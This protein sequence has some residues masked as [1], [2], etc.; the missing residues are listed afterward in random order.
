MQSFRNQGRSAFQP[1]SMRLRR[2]GGRSTKMMPGVNAPITV[3]PVTRPRPIQP[4]HRLPQ[5]QPPADRYDGNPEQA[6]RRPSD[7]PAPPRI[8]RK[9]YRGHGHESVSQSRHTEIAGCGLDNPPG[10]RKELRDQPSRTRN[11]K[12]GRHENGSR[13]PTRSKRDPACPRFEVS[14]DT[15]ADHC[16]RAHAESQHRG[17]NQEFEARCQSISGQSLDTETGGIAGGRRYACN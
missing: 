4:G 14:A 16:R 2:F 3:E 1:E 11:S 8:G 12:P 5:Q 15:G 13:Q 9:Q 7:R 10:L 17:K 6:H